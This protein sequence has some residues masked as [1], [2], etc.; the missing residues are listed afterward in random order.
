MYVV[1]QDGGTA[2]SFSKG[3]QADAKKVST[4]EPAKIAL[5]QEHIWHDQ[6]QE[7]AGPC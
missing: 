3:L 6:Q 7:Q 1:G 5:A 2:K 4:A